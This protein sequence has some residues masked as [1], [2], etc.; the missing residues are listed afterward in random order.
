MAV[1][2]QKLLPPPSSALVKVGKIKTSKK[3]ENN[4]TDSINTID[5]IKKELEKIKENLEKI[6]SLVLDNNK[7]TEKDLEVKRLS[8]ERLKFAEKE[9]RLETKDPE[10]KD[11]RDDK[12]I[13]KLGIFDRINR[14]ITFTLL[15]WVAVRLV[16]YLPKLLEFSKNLLP[17]MEFFSSFTANFFK[18]V[19]DFI[20]F[21]YNAYDKV[22]DFVKGIGG[23]P[24]EK[25]FDDFSSN[26]N[27]FV[28]LAIIAGIAASGGT[29]FGLGKKPG[30]LGSGLGGGSSQK[31]TIQE[32]VKNSR[33][34]N[35]QRKYGP[36]ARKIYENA[37]NNGKTPQQA[38]AA[39]RKGIKKGVSI[40]PGA[41]SLSAKTAKKGSVLS[42]GV[43]K[44][45]NRL[46]TKVLGKAGKKLVGKAF[47]KIP[48]IGGLVSF[49]ISVLSGEPVGRAA[50]KAVG[51]S[52]GSALGTF[53]PVPFVGT[54]LGGMLGD[55][56]GGALYDTLVSNK[57]EETPE[58]VA[59]R[60]G[61]RVKSNSTLET[62]NQDKKSKIL[63][64]GQSVLQKGTRERIIDHTGIDPIESRNTGGFNKENIESRNTGGLLGFNKVFN[65][66]N[67]ESRNTGGFNKENIES[68]NTGGL[69][70]FNKVFNKENI[71][72]RNTGGFNKE[73]IE[74]RNT[75]GLLGFNKVFNK[76]NIESRNTG[77][78]NKENIESRNTG[79]LL[80]FNKVFNKENIESRN[81]GGF[82]KENIESRNTGGLL[83]F[84]KVFNK[85]NIESRNTGGFNKENIESR[86]TG[87]LLGFNKGNI[88]SRN[89]GGF[90]KENIESRNT[91]GLL[92]FNK[93]N[94]ESRNTG[95]FNKE[96]IESRNTGGLLGFNKGN[97]ESRNTGGFNKENIESRNTGGLLGFNKE[98]IESRNTGGFNKE[99]NNSNITRGGKKVGGPA[100]RKVRRVVK[101][102]VTPPKSTPIAAGKSVGGKEKLKELFPEPS[103]GQVGKSMDPYGYTTGTS[104]KLGQIPFLGPLFNI[105]GKTLLGDLPNKS[106]Y[107]KVGM[108]LGAWINTAVSQ[109]QLQGNIV[110]AF[111]DGGMIEGFG[112]SDISGWVEKSVEELVKNK[113]TEAINELKRNLGLKSII[114]DSSLDFDDKS[115]FDDPIEAVTPGVWGPLLDLIASKESGGNYEAMYPSTVLR[116]ATKMT[117]SEVARRATGAVGKY[118]QL[119]QYLI[120]RARAAGLNPDRDLYSPQNQD[121][122]VTKVN[123]GQ[124]R[125]GNSWLRGEISDEVFMQ[126]LSMEFAALPNARGNFYYTGQR[127]SIRPEQVKGALSKVKR[128]GNQI[129]SLGRDHRGIQDR[130]RGSTGPIVDTGIRDYL[131]RPIKF[132][133]PAAR[134]FRK[135]S[136]DASKQGINL[137]PGISSTLR[138]WGATGSRHKTGEAFDINW[139][140][141]AG[142]WIRNNANKYGFRYNPYSSRSTHFD[143]IGKKDGGIIGQNIK[144][145]QTQ[146][147][148]DDG[149]SIVM[150]IQPVIIEKPIPM[151]TGGNKIAFIGGVN[152]NN[153]NKSSLFVG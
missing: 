74:S 123:I 31:L 48:I 43:G 119:P 9:K 29:D 126:R 121:I 127:S 46:S 2:P 37:L 42:R 28:N 33:I 67:I 124:N 110:S 133:S 130:G 134:Q 153:T 18:G 108:G 103:Q 102:I 45:V 19:V 128:G 86:N 88:E 122:I 53:I 58:V 13:P 47:G 3:S 7:L 69:L 14:F 136:L 120:S 77:G 92:G 131:G 49:I 61:G 56:V 80:G 84:N 68:R 59:K 12:S 116:G 78:F 140:T 151:R 55:I 26:L 98:N 125:G 22:K 15:G 115:Y 143:W 72:S 60:G 75:G 132:V 81:T 11:E 39:V 83:G 113:V 1:N 23:E 30:K 142:V 44:S 96:N 20:D 87:G 139:N 129:S 152:S 149:Q 52:I 65:K 32:R 63:Y 35:I 21:G 100:Q 34:R 38:E 57:K 73:N 17:V 16:K 112:R 118:Q 95:G 101:R 111:S 107:Q 114:D 137:G 148:Y 5:A 104:E 89:T 150:L 91:G 27:K 71:E 105:F 10:K 4:S 51:F 93:G 85:E 24:F 70:G 8:A 41:D 146:A 54:I 40:R 6:Y 106:D 90:N 36:S 94:I 50:A 99:N 145:I 147:S 109:G 76:E 144:S 97:I 138:D 66:E 62:F 79:G 135:M 25:A 82:N 64:P 117:I 141:P